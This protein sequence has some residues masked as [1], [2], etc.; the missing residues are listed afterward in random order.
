MSVTGRAASALL[1]FVAATCGGATA[2]PSPAATVTA[3]ASPTAAGTVSAGG[4]WTFTVDSSSKATVRVR[5]VLARVQL[6]GDAVLTATRVT[7][8]FTLN[9]DGTFAPASKITVD[10]TTLRSDQS[11]RDEFIKD[12]T[13]QTRRFPTAEFVPTKTSGL[14]LPLALSGDLTFTLTGN[15]TIHGTTKEVTFDVKAARSGARLTATATAS[16]TW[17]FGDFG[18]TIPRVATVLSIQ[19]DIRLEVALVATETA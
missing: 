18:M 11:Q 16:P 7:G 15:M 1:I 13:L 6:P 8:S 14:P 4:P 17:K 5:E 10:L 12:N 2:G 3:T 19:D 9:T